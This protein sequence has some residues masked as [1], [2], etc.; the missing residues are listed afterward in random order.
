MREAHGGSLR[1]TFS[2]P[3]VAPLIAQPQEEAAFLLADKPPGA[4][5]WWRR[6]FLN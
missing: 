2:H 5:L 3:L 4:L 6:R 1:V